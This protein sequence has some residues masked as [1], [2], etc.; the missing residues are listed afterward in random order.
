VDRLCFHNQALTVVTVQWSENNNA[1][2]VAL[3]NNLT[4][5]SP[6]KDTHLYLQS[7][8]GL[9]ITTNKRHYAEKI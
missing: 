5:P 6:Y 4:Q 2:N 7:T 8:S 1:M 9:Q 3:Y